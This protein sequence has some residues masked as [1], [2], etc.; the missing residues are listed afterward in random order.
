[1]VSLNVGVEYAQ[2][3]GT[4]RLFQGD[5]EVSLSF[6]L[7]TERHLKEFIRRLD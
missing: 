4:L 6:D 7:I 5:K 1:M 3:K 2:E